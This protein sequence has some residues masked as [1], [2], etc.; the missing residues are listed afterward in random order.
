MSLLDEQFTDLTLID[1]TTTPDGYGGVSTVWV[2]GA[3]IRGAVVYDGSSEALVAQAMGS[4]AVYTVT[5]RRDVQLDY[6]SVLRRERDKKIFRIT[7][8][9]DDFA[10][11]PSA[12]LDMRQYR[13][14][15]WELPK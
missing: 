4:T 11:P 10:T 3:E 7:N 8:N 6:H 12:A 15:E 5:V 9:S 2:D 13:A 1:K 14:E